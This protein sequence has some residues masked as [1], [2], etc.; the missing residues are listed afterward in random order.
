MN[1]INEYNINLDLV[2]L[3]KLSIQAEEIKERNVYS[4]LQKGQIVKTKNLPTIINSDGF[5]AIECIYNCNPFYSI[6]KTDYDKDKLNIEIISVMF[7]EIE[8][9]VIN[10]IIKENNKITKKVNEYDLMFTIIQ[11]V[12]EFVIGLICTRYIDLDNIEKKR[13]KESINR[14]NTY[15][16]NIYDIFE[17]EYLSDKINRRIKYIIADQYAFINALK[18][19]LKELDNNE[20]DIKK[21]IK[22]I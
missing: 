15:L 20:E 17:G 21:Y 2:T 14:A 4:K 12:N 19:S 1:K 3:E 10:K 9:N 11:K 22:Q 7:T 18:Y 16:K 8:K 6:I 5:F 13:I